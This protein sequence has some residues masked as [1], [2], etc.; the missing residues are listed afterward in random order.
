MQRHQKR[1]AS[2]CLHYLHYVQQTV[3]WRSKKHTQVKN[4][5]EINFACPYRQFHYNFDTFRH[6]SALFVCDA[7]F[8][9]IVATFVREDLCAMQYFSTL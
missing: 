3:Q 6:D 5:D 7:I 4:S 1:S 2:L 9:Y 8:L